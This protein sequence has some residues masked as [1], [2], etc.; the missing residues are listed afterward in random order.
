MN[1]EHLNPI[2]AA[3]KFVINQTCGIELKPGKPYVTQS[4]Y[5]DDVFVV[6][7]G[8]TGQLHGQVILAMSKEI[9]KVL[10]SKMMMGMPVPELN[11]MA[12][13][14]LGELMNMMMGNAMTIFAEKN[15]LLDITP[16]TIFVSKDL[17]LN[18][19]DSRMIAIPLE[20]DAGMLELN[21]AI[22]EG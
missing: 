4:E 5:T 20:F 15:I 2:I 1:A 13:S 16:P 17:S 14:A 3:S 12:K 9:A 19:G 18:V 21:I 8:I 10:A 11:D 7:L 6:L 22:K